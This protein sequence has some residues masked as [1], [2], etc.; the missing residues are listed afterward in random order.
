MAVATG[1]YSEDDLREAGAHATFATLESTDD[2]LD[3]ILAVVR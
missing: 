1:A 2:V 3:S